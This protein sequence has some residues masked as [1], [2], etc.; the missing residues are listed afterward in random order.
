V[1]NGVFSFWQRYSHKIEMDP[2]SLATCCNNWGVELLQMHHSA[3]YAMAT[4]QRAAHIM[5]DVTGMIVRASSLEMEKK[6]YRYPQSTHYPSVPNTWTFARDMNICTMPCRSLF[7]T[8]KTLC[9]LDKGTYY[10]YNRPFVLSTSC[11]SSSPK[12]L[13]SCMMTASAVIVFNLG[14]SFQQ[15]AKQCNRTTPIWQ[16]MLCYQLTL[17]MIQQGGIQREFGK[18]L[19][20][21]A[22]NNLANIHYD[23]CDFA[24]TKTCLDRL[25]DLIGND[26]LIRVFASVFMDDREW[27]DLKLNIMSSR[28]SVTAQAA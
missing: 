6:A 27:S 20:C 8:Y 22:L 25:R 11:P 2:W 28:F 19:M 26:P 7:Q 16:A 12:E 3:V 10:V 13:A 18:F 21:L 4:F 23:L 15:Y 14:I 9:S 5:K 1:A 17:R 24:M